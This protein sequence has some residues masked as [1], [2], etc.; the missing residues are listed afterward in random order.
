[1]QPCELQR[2]ITKDVKARSER[3]LLHL[4]LGLEACEIA[5]DRSHRKNAALALVLQPAILCRDLAI[6]GNLIPCLGMTDIIDRH[7]VMLAPEKRHGAECL[8]LAQHI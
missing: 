8:L 5:I 7:V 1:M 3:R 6:D 2:E 4:K